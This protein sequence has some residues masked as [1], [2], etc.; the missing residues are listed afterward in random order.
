MRDL[1]DGLGVRLGRVM[2]NAKSDEAQLATASDDLHLE[3]HA[4]A[5][6]GRRQVDLEAMGQ[7]GAFSSFGV[8]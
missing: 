6:R 8:A 1:V 7:L 4:K 3:H 2:A 5:A